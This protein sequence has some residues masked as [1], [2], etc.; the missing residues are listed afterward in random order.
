MIKSN[1]TGLPVV[2]G[3]ASGDVMSWRQKFSFA[4]TGFG[5][6]LVLPEWNERW[7]KKNEQLVVQLADQKR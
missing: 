6:T 1:K 5:F 3:D 4:T 2:L 7:E